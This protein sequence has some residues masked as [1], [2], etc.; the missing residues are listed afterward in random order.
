MTLASELPR[1]LQVNE[2]ADQI[3]LK[4][5]VRRRATQNQ[6]HGG[7]IGTGIG[8]QA[9]G[10]NKTPI[11]AAKTTGAAVR[12][13]VKISV[14]TRVSSSCRVRNLL[15]QVRV[16]CRRTVHDTGHIR[17]GDSWAVYPNSDPPPQLLAREP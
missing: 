10:L 17:R 7:F 13:R 6:A 5:A 4:I 11:V 16:L 14:G 8:I 2:I 1:V 3:N 9:H 15:A 12:I